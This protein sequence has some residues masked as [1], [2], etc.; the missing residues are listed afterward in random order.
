[1]SPSHYITARDLFLAHHWAKYPSFDREIF[2]G[3]DC[4]RVISKEEDVVSLDTRRSHSVLAWSKE[5][6]REPKAA[7]VA[8]PVR[9]VLTVGD[10]VGVNGAGDVML[11]APCMSRSLALLPT[12][13]L[14]EGR[15]L[16]EQAHS[17]STFIKTVR[18]FFTERG[19]SEMTTPTLAASPGTEPFLDPLSVL[20]ESSGDVVEKYLITSPEFHLKKA[21]AA[22]L[23]RVFEIAKCFRNKEGGDHHRVEFHMLEWYRSFASLHE[24]ADDVEALIRTVQTSVNL[25]FAPPTSAPLRRTT[26]Q[27]LFR[28]MIES[29]SGFVLRPETSRSELASFAKEIG[30]RTVEEDSF[31]DIFHRIFLEKIELHL[32]QENH[33]GP[34]LISG[35]PPSM[36]AL[37][38]IDSDGFADR[39]EVY[40]RGL[41]LCNAFHELNDPVENRRRFEADN[42]SKE[43]SGRQPVP[44]DQDLLRSFDHG[45]PPAGGIALGLERL[46]MAVYGV[47]NI[48]KVRPFA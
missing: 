18:D 12:A 26:M 23:P 11:F 19:F 1:M 34:V 8:P 39:F 41:E 15:A 5:C 7:E 48:A 25:E 20:V 21:L 32:P 27:E 46:Y 40:W 43:Q 36:A 33:G 16:V 22:G 38:R 30:V 45:V 29:K 28:E 37:S 3:F 42:R 47:S 44:I 2:E 10:W 31:D 24:I 17:W 13:I 4:G 9:E 14:Q 35:Y 6:L